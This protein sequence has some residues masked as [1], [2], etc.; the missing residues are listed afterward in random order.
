[1]TH[2]DVADSDGSYTACVDN[3]LPYGRLEESRVVTKQDPVAGLMIEG[4]IKFENQYSFKWITV[5][6]CLCYVQSL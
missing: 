2:L 1:M 6:Q 5:T 4:R 3:E